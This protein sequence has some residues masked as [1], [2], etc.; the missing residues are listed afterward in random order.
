MACMST[1]RIPTPLS[2]E[3][4]QALVESE[5]DL[6]PS[7]WALKHVQCIAR[8][9]TRQLSLTF[10]DPNAPPLV[11]DVATIP[12]LVQ[13]SDSDLRELQLSPAGDTLIS[14]ALDVHIS[15]EGLVYT[16]FVASHNDFV[17]QH[18]LPLA[19]RRIADLL[20]TPGADDVDVEAPPRDELARGADLS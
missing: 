10:L 5:A 6:T 12:E 19:A 20:A 14:E 15:V 4:Y 18:G 1:R 8:S 2:V 17:E 7:P 16:E 13:A 11:I 3:A 9:G